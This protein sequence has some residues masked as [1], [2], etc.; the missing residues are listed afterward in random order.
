MLL[1]EGTVMRV[2][3]TMLQRQAGTPFLPGAGKQ[4]C[5]RPCVGQ[6][7]N[8]GRQALGKLEGKCR[9]AGVAVHEWVWARRMQAARAPN[10]RS[11][12]GTFRAGRQTRLTHLEPL[13]R[14]EPSP[15]GRSRAGRAGSAS[16]E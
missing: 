1:L 5:R 3:P 2:W 10:P 8:T 6:V 12:S 4:A 16:A 15:A 11:A 14:A 7:V 13:G 9:P